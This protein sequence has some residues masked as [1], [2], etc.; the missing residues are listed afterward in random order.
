[1]R[2]KLP[3]EL[4]HFLIFPASVLVWLL[5]VLLSYLVNQ[6]LK[7]ISQG[8][9]DVFMQCVGVAF[10]SIFTPWLVSNSAP[11]GKKIYYKAIGVLQIISLSIGVIYEMNI[12]DEKYIAPCIWGIVMSCIVFFSAKSR[13]EFF[14]Q[15]N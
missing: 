10:A 4:R 7:L 11:S 13:Q 15:G 1:M 2:I 5:F 14:G 6:I 3:P 8:G 9:D 12:D